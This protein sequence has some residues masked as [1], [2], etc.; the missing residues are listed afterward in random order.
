[1][2][3]R[4]MVILYRIATSGSKKTLRQ[5][6]GVIALWQGIFDILPHA[7][8][9]SRQCAFSQDFFVKHGAFLMPGLR[10]RQGGGVIATR[11]RPATSSP[12]QSFD[13]ILFVPTVYKLNAHNMCLIALVCG[14]YFAK[15]NCRKG[16][17]APSIETRR[18]GGR[19]R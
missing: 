13:I 17:F 15:A 8:M 14:L 7:F 2:D 10:A 3:R 9:L 19:R 18:A 1:M 5:F 6:Q 11:W 4:E 12:F 16:R